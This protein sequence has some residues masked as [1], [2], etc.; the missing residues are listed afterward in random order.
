[1]AR[2]E[3]HG[4]DRGVDDVGAGLDGLHEADQR[5][6]GGGVAVDV[7]LDVLAVGLLDAADDVV[8]GLGLQQCS[9]VLQRDGVGAH[10]EQAAGELDVALGGVERGDG[11]A[12]GAL[13]VLAGLLDRGHRAGHVAGVVEGV[14]DAEDVHAV[15]GGL[16]DELV[17]DVVLV[18]AIAEQVLPAQQHLQ[19]AVGHQF[20]ERPQPLPGIFVQ[21]SDASVVGRAAPTLDAPIACSVDVGTRINHVF[22]GHASRHEALV[23]VAQRNFGHTDG[24]WAHDF[25]RAT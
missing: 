4:A 24:S 19:L 1:V 3:A 10:V 20:A 2:A 17:D 12:D 5:D 11:V 18:V 6:A 7:D 14:E 8:G 23:R 21:E 25:H 22:H 15:L 13:G 9:H 16:L